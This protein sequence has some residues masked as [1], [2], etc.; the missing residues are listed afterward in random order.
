MYKVEQGRVI[1][2]EI[3]SCLHSVNGTIWYFIAIVTL[4]SYF[5][6]TFRWS[7]H[8]W[9][10]IWCWW[11]ASCYWKPQLQWHWRQSNKLLHHLICQQ[12]HK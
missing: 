1:T 3:V 6:T 10:Q 8:Q 7:C 2:I 11:H 9:I 12:Y 4:A 5:A